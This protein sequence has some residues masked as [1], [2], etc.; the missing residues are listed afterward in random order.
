[1]NQEK[2]LEEQARVEVDQFEADGYKLVGSYI[3]G[4]GSDPS[5]LNSA[6]A[7]KNPSYDRSGPLFLLDDYYPLGVGFYKKVED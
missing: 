6:A 4:V 1:M 3:I 5:V 7:G 2:S